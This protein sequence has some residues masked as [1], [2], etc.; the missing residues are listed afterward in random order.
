MSV[1]DRGGASRAARRRRS[2]VRSVA[3]LALTGARGSRDSLCG[4]QPRLAASAESRNRKSRD[5]SGRAGRGGAST[6]AR[7]EVRSTD[8]PGSIPPGAEGRFFDGEIRRFCDRNA[9][10]F[11]ATFLIALGI[12]VMMV[13]VQQYAW[14]RGALDRGR[15]LCESHRRLDPPVLRSERAAIPGDVPNRAR[16]HRNGRLGSAVHVHEGRSRS[17]TGAL[18]ESPAAR[19][20]DD[21]ALREDRRLYPGRR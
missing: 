15:A 17:R 5:V 12:I 8:P 13:S 9:Q 20:S 18:R 3:L 16:H 6:M 10:L 11:L 19:P 14:T 1:H 4:L 7:A 21:P 2:S